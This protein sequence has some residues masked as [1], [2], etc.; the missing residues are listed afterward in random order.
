[1]AVV[2]FDPTL[3]RARRVATSPAPLAPRPPAVPPVR[4]AAPA[5]AP[6]R[7]RVNLSPAAATRTLA[8]L[9]LAIA[10]CATVATTLSLMRGPAAGSD[11]AATLA[12][13]RLTGWLVSLPWLFLAVTLLAVSRIE[14][15]ARATTDHAWTLLAVVAALVAATQ[16]GGVEALRLLGPASRTVLVVALAVS[17][18]VATRGLLVGESR[19][20]RTQLLVAITGG[21]A[22]T[23]GPFST[24]GDL[25]IPAGERNAALSALLTG[26][27]G[28]LGLVVA[29]LAV[30]AALMYVRD[31]LPDFSIALDTTDEEVPARRSSK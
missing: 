5:P 2:P 22:L 14:R 27:D 8:V 26:S 20:L 31:C 15:L 17:V 21:L 30:H 29:T 25:L 16:V 18:V 3:A 24:V 12:V 10:F 9:G 6:P 1:M 11:F 19:A 23:C 28:L 4:P 13:G 7:L